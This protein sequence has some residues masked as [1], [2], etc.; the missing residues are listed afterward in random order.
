MSNP[1]PEW[2]SVI[3]VTAVV[4]LALFAVGTTLPTLNVAW[5]PTY[6]GDFGL[7]NYCPI[8]SVGSVERGS[9]AWVADIRPGDKIEP[10]FNSMR[11]R[12]LVDF[13]LGVRPGE[14]LIVRILRGDTTRTVT[15][16]ARPGASKPLAEDILIIVKGVVAVLFIA[17]G[18]CLVLLRPSL[19]MWSFYFYSAGMSG[20]DVAT[21]TFWSFLPVGLY[22]FINIARSIMSVAAVVGFLIFVLRF[23]QNKA[24]GWRRALEFVAIIILVLLLWAYPYRHAMLEFFGTPLWGGINVVPVLLLATFALTGIA[25]I[26]SYYQARGSDRQ[27]IKWLVVALA[28]SC[29]AILPVVLGRGVQRVS[30]PLWAQQLG[31]IILS[32]AVPLSV[33]YATIHHRVFDIK[34]IISRALVYTGITLIV[35]A[36]FSLI[37]LIVSKT[38]ENVT[39]GLVADASAAIAIGIALNSLHTRLNHALDWIFFQEHNRARQRMLSLANKLPHAKSNNSVNRMLVAGPVE[40]FRLTSGAVFRRSD[41]ERYIRQFAIGW[42]KTSYQELAINDPLVRQL[43]DLG[44]LTRM[45]KMSESKQTFFGLPTGEARPI[46]A[47]PIMARHEL[48]AFALY[49]AHENGADLDPDEVGS[50]GNLAV[51]AAVAYQHLEAESM[52][53]KV[54]SL[55]SQNESLRTQLAG[56][57]R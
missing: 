47:L 35:V 13:D 17:V 33:V 31:A 29:V 57:Q 9:A 12:L 32:V 7:C 54:D 45:S 5:N 49:G 50:I 23:P 51:G 18:A 52:K 44:V 38:L 1:K 43:R 36:V 25:I 30:I 10:K 19:M 22:A 34:F 40:A 2:R 46:L 20:A 53:R 27:K 14:K 6:Y 26:V 42:S 16:I 55:M 48:L 41:K 11:D 37:N 3:R 56:A 24:A 15:L 28:I 39:L 4:A 21:A 8:G